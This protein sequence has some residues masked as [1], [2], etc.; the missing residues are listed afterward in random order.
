[1]TT[2]RRLYTREW[3]EGD[4][5]IEAQMWRLLRVFGKHTFDEICNGLDLEKNPANR[6][7]LDELKRMGWAQSSGTKVMKIK[8]RNRIVGVY[9]ALEEPIAIER[10]PNLARKLNTIIMDAEKARLSG[11]PSVQARA[12]LDI[13]E[14]LRK[15]RDGLPRAGDMVLR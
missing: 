5:H 2:K 10:K 1:M 13:T 11:L 14:R 8:G 9:E 15:I 7:H 6:H 12:L 4:D 3:L